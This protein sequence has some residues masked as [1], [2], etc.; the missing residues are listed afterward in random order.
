MAH[1]VFLRGVN[2][3]GHKTFRP[4]ELAAELEHLEAVNI[5]AAGTFV[6]HKPVSEARLRAELASRL[7]FATQVAI[8]DGRDITQLIR[9]APFGPRAPQPGIVRF[10]SILP[11]SI[12]RT[13]PTPLRWPDKGHWL[14]RVLAIE[15]RFI[16]GEYRR[17]M[18]TIGYLGGLDEVVGMP[19]TTRNWRTITA[20]AGVLAASVATKPGSVSR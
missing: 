11:R 17:N 18:K 5:G 12:D 10:I 16:I 14:V 13:P 9:R 15:R 3:G 8:C 4:T 20:I 7:P 1:V 6:I 2:V 19:V